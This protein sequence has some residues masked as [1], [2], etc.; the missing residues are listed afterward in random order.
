[1]KGLLAR[2]NQRWIWIF[3]IATFLLSALFDYP[4]FGPKPLADHGGIY[5]WLVM[6]CPGIVALVLV[7]FGKVKVREL[8]VLNPG[9]IHLAWGFLLPVLIA[10]PLYAL[11]VMTGFGTFTPSAINGH[12]LGSLLLLPRAL[13]KALGEEIGWRGYLFP[14]LRSRFS[15]PVASLISGSVWALWHFAMIV[16]GGYLDA[17]RVPLSAALVFFTLGLIGQSFVYG[18]LRERSGS[19][20]PAVCLHGVWNWF[21]QG[22]MGYLFKPEPNSSLVVGEMSVGIAVMGVVLAAVFWNGRQG[23]R[24]KVALP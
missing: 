18:W 6:W 3:T 15:F 8:G 1:M 9:G 7:A 13:G 10:G 24:Q 11:A 22:V 12:V 17:A 14:Q 2:S 5:G 19:V 4:L 20:W 23:N 21:T 16:Q